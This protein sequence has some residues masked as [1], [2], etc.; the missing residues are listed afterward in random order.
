[1]CVMVRNWSGFYS[2]LFCNKYNGKVFC[3][4]TVSCNL[5]LQLCSIEPKLPHSLELFLGAW[6]E[7]SEDYHATH[8]VQ[9]FLGG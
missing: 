4:Q 8:G 2:T 5:Q 9:C 7:T 1:M 6:L 3:G